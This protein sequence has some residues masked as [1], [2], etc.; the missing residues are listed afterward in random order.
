MITYAIKLRNKANDVTVEIGIPG[1]PFLL[2][3]Q[4]RVI[5][6]AVDS[7][8]KSGSNSNWVEVD[9]DGNETSINQSPMSYAEYRARE[10]ANAKEKKA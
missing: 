10:E 9:A 3:Q 5:A 6:A 1:I 2:N 8:I 7:V 4:L